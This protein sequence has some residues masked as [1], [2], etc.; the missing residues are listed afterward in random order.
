MCSQSKENREAS[1]INPFK[2]NPNVIKEG[3]KVFVE[4]CQ[5]CHGVVGTGDVCPDLTDYNWIYGSS[6]NDPFTTI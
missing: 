3:D 5:S 2:G 6:N 1:I 4:N